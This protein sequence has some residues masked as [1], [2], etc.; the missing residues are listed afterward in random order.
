MGSALYLFSVIDESLV[1]GRI[2]DFLQRNAMQRSI[3]GLRNHVIICG[4]GASA[5]RCQRSCF[6]SGPRW[7]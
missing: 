6:A 1:E 7:S 2:Q 5:E 3:D 4:W